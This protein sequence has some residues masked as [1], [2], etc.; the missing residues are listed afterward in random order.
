V[1]P[2]ILLAGSRLQVALRQYLPADRFRVGRAERLDQVLVLRKLPLAH[3][4]KHI[5]CLQH[6]VQVRFSA[7]PPVLHLVLVARDLE[8][9]AVALEAHDGDVREALL[10]CRRIGGA[11]GVAAVLSRMRAACWRQP[12]GKLGQART[13]LLL[14][15]SDQLLCRVTVVC[16]GEPLLWH[17]V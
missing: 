16:C 3:V 11:L 15:D 5:L 9:L 10:A 4:G 2:R 12:R 7:C 17:G 1:S 13:R 6:L 14:F 8:A